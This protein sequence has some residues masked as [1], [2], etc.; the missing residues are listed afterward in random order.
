VRTRATGH[1][2][3]MSEQS[4]EDAA[5]GGALESDEGRPEGESAEDPAEG[6]DDP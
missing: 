3:A 2:S 6:S 5:E 4:S 1:L